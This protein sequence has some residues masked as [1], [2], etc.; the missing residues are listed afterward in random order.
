MYVASGNGG[1]LMGGETAGSVGPNLLQQYGSTAAVPLLKIARPDDG[2]FMNP[3]K[4]W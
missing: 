2:L 4:S 3:H 1:T